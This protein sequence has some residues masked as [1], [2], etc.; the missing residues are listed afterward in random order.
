MR[1]PLTTIFCLILCLA[2]P[3]GAQQPKIRG[4][5]AMPRGE[6]VI[7]RM[8]LENLFAP[9]IV[10]TIR[11]G[12]PAIVQHDFR[13]L[14]ENGKEKG[15]ALQTLEVKYD[16]WAQRFR[17]AFPDTVRIAATFEEAER[18]LQDFEMPVLFMPALDRSST[19][20]LRLRVVV[21]PISA[22]Q[23]RQLLQRLAANDFEVDNTTTE[24]GRSGFSLDLSSLISFFFAGEERAHGASDWVASPP[25]R[26]TGQP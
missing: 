17:L 16:I 23:N 14:A 5:N 8:R 2:W 24:A 21:I 13:L 1:R 4:L 11:S 20:R 7:A 22:E 25:F 26:W 3:L 12:L 18:M 15:R 6:R 19:Y 9:K 10:S